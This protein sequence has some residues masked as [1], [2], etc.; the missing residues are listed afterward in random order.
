MKITKSQLKQ[1]IRE[2]L[3]DPGLRAAEG[4]SLSLAK[5]IEDK[6]YEV[7]DAIAALST[8]DVEGA[9]SMLEMVSEDLEGIA[10]RVDELENKEPPCPPIT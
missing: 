8:G 3:D 1:L 7:E 9:M 4:L 6:R 5:V 10:A 2:T